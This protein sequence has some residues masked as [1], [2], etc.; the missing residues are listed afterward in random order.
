MVILYNFISVLL[1]IVYKYILKRGNKFL[2]DSKKIA[3]YK[4]KA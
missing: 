2:E 4:K 1:I 3:L